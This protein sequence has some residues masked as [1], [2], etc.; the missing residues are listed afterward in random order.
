MKG[1]QRVVAAAGFVVAACA[2]AA[3]GSP[4]GDVHR[5]DGTWSVT[6]TCADYRDAGQGAKGYTFR[7]LGT[8]E[9]GA[10]RAEHGRAGSPSW[11]LYEGRVEADGTAEIRAKGLTGK[12]DYAVGQVGTGTRYSYRLKG[13]FDAGRGVAKRVDLRPCEAIFVRQ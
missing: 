12:P 11:L 10:L 8:I 2:Y 5:F 9:N 1:W 13:E 6:L 3:D 7:F 4:A